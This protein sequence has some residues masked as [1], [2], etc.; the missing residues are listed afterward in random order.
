M[1]KRQKHV[2]LLALL[3][4]YMA[5]H[6]HTGSNPN[7]DTKAVLIITEIKKFSFF[8]TADSSLCVFFSSTVKFHTCTDESQP[9]GGSER[10]H[11]CDQISFF[12]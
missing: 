6:T 4:S 10:P 9:L 11:S 1:D 3:F 2:Q 7:N 8:C 12:P 5:T